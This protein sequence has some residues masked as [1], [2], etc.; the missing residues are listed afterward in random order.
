MFPSHDRSGTSLTVSTATLS[1]NLT[2]SG[3][4]ANGVLYL[5]GSK[6]ATS[7][8]ALVF[9]GTNFATTG[10]GTLKNLLLSG[11]TLP[12]AGNP[13][14]SLRSSD[15]V[16]YH[17]S[18]SANTIVMLDSS[19]NTMQSIGATAQIWNISNA[20]QM[21]L[22]STGLGIGTASPVSK[23]HSTGPITQQGGI[24]TGAANATI[25]AN[26]SGQ[27]QLWATGANASTRG[28][29]NFVTARS[30]LSSSIEV[31]KCDTSGNLEA[32]GNLGLG[33]TPSAWGGGILGFQN[34]NTYFASDIGPRLF[35]GANAYYDGAWKY[36]ANGY[37]T[38]HRSSGAEGD[39]Q[40][41]VAP[42]GTAGNAITFT[43]AM[44]LNASGGLKCL[45]TI[46]VGNATPAASGA[47]VTFPATQSASS[48]ANTLDDYE[49]GTFTP[50]V[51]GS[52]TAGTGTYIVQVGRYTKI[53][54]RVSVDVHMGWSAHTGTGNMRFTDLPFTIKNASN[55]FAAGAV[56]SSDNF[57][58]TANN[59]MTLYAANN[60]NYLD[61]R[62]YPAGGGSQT[63]VPMDTAAGIIFSVNYEV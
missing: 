18:G 46:G 31:L 10:S 16:I 23:V 62:Q 49:T 11:G 36:L 25:L 54:N 50:T 34:R 12:G 8:S 59:I 7:G 41:A 27:A 51:S 6:V 45:N 5:N 20:E 9:D 22:T 57:A 43:Q 60:T 24:S 32:S 61:V 63:A 3:G 44:E 15:N 53:G 28:T 4:T 37:A 13:S 17:Q 21:R 33:V 30:D 40:W 48:D 2:L 26:N 14:I 35:V 47:G 1:S 42:S 56:G 55:Y 19:Q 58:L 52:T 29:F 39:F 38:R